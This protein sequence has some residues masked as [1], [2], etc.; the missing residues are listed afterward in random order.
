MVW[1]IGADRSHW[2]DEDL[3]ELW[4]QGYRFL[5]IKVSE[6]T[7]FE[8]PAWR[9]THKQ[10]VAIGFKVGPYHWLTPYLN[11]TRQV[12]WHWNLIKDVDW[13]MPT[14]LDVEQHSTLSK[15]V[16]FARVKAFLFEI[17]DLSS[18]E[19]I[20]YTSASKWNRY[21]DAYVPHKLMIA[22]YTTRPHP[23]LPRALAANGYWMWQFK[24]RPVDTDRLNATWNEFLEW[25]EE[26]PEPTI[27]ERV[28]AIEEWIENH[29]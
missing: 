13:D 1:I 2:N 9:E 7:G 23:T 17:E 6:G 27:E 19:P 29:G 25:I 21:V 16:Y 15:S 14:M 20:I 12:A 24:T 8:D 5:Y 3:Q 22:H 26:E 11:A 28:M 4:D 10:A 18:R